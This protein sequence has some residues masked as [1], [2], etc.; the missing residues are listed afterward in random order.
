MRQEAKR[1]KERDQP[2]ER[3][4]SSDSRLQRIENIQAHYSEEDQ[5]EPRT[6]DDR[7]EAFTTPLKVWRM[8]LGRISLFTSLYAMNENA[9]FPSVDCAERE[10]LRDLYRNAVLDCQRVGG[11]DAE[12]LNEAAVVQAWKKVFEARYAVIGHRRKHK[13]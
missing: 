6:G 7:P 4:P 12:R 3:N 10:R 13:C 9:G 11:N 1:G 2:Y 8:R 5:F